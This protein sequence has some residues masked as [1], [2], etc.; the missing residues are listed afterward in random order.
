M[1]LKDNTD[2]TVCD[3]RGV[4]GSGSLNCAAQ[5]STS[6]VAEISGVVETGRPVSALGIRLGSLGLCGVKTGL[7]SRAIFGSGADSSLVDHAND[8]IISALLGSKFLAI[9]GSS[10]GLHETWVVNKITWGSSVLNTDTSVRFLKDDCE[11]ESWVNTVGLSFRL[12]SGREV[13][14]LSVAVLRNSICAR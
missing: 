9:K 6:F 12:D 2:E 4:G 1:R 13:L 14:V 5:I 3:V 7:Q 8:F 10:M 11:N